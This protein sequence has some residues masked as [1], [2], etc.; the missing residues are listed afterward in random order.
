MQCHLVFLT[1]MTIEHS[2]RGYIL[3]TC[4]YIESVSLDC[5]ICV[6]TLKGGTTMIKQ[7]HIYTSL[8]QPT[9][10][11]R[12]FWKAR[13]RWQRNSEISFTVL[14]P[15]HVCACPKPA[16]GFPSVN[17]SIFVFNDLKWGVNVRFVDISGIVGHGWWQFLS[18]IFNLCTE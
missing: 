9:V 11:G 15:S 16:P 14:T 8:N 4:K 2:G 17:Y 10:T 1:L 7:I 12:Q 3:S 18:T 13:Y 5:W 6:S